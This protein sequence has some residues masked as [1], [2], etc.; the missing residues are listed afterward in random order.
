MVMHD[1]LAVNILIGVFFVL[2]LNHATVYSMAL[3]ASFFLLD[4]V[5]IF[6]WS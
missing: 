2:E 6:I 1:L 5:I 3:E 4:V